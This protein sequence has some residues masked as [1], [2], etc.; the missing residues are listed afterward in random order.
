MEDNGTQPAP[1]RQNIDPHVPHV[2]SG[3]QR[4]CSTVVMWYSI[5]WPTPHHIAWMKLNAQMI[6]HYPWTRAK[7]P[8]LSHVYQLFSNMIRNSSQ[9]LTAVNQVNRP[10]SI[11]VPTSH[12]QLQPRDPRG[13]ASR[14]SL[15]KPFRTYAHHRFSSV[16][17]SRGSP[18]PLSRSSD[19]WYWPNKP[20]ALW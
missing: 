11:S 10:W 15:S 14:T 19:P 20:I 18:V 17:G 12:E 7:F 5:P 1:M 9:L 4:N 16:Q 3:A 13:P 6:K 8:Q 2:Q